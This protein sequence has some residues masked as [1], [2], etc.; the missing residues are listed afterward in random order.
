MHVSMYKL[1]MSHAQTHI[2]D[3]CRSRQ[4]YLH[5]HMRR[6]RMER[7]TTNNIH[8]RLHTDTYTLI[9]VCIC[10]THMYI[11]IYIH[12]Y[13]YIYIHNYIYIYIYIIIYIYIYNYIHSHGAT[14]ELESAAPRMEVL[15]RATVKSCF[16]QQSGSNSL[17]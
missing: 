14:R 15:N 16:A 12:I 5:T 2:I 11:Y 8:P 1:H 17:K 13:I 10:Y 3:T 4:R 9:D 7:L 6:I